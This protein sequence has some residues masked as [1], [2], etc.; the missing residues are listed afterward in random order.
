MNIIFNSSCIYSLNHG[1]LAGEAGHSLSLKLVRITKS[2]FNNAASSGL[3][4]Y[5]LELL[6]PAKDLA[7]NIKDLKISGNL[8]NYKAYAK[9]QFKFTNSEKEFIDIKL[10]PKMQV[11]FF[12]Q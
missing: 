9:C 8:P 12:G 5:K 11:K 3:Q 10:R 6:F 7:P 1:L 4:I 2:N